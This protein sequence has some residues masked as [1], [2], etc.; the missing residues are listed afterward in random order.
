MKRHRKSVNVNAILYSQN[1]SFTTLIN[2]INDFNIYSKNNN[3]DINII[4]NVITQSNFTH[5]L[6][7]YETLLDYLF[8][9]KSEKYDIIFYDNIYRMRFAPH[10]IDL[11]NILPVDHVDMYMEG[12]ANQTSICNDKLIGLPISVDADVL[13]YNKNYLKKYNQ[14]VPRTW[15]DLIKI[16]KYISNEEK[17]QNNTNLIIYQG[18]FPNHEGGM[19]STYE[20]I[21]SFRDSVNS[22]FPGLTSQIAI[23]ALDKIK[24]IK[25]EIST[26]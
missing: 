15:D 5:S 25:N 22:S 2:I 4:T 14:K 3:L 8:L 21:Y 13:Y 18:Y 16:G 9:K 12:V 26:G 10:L 6:T 24:E 1:G 7:D 11:K 17:K 20:F 19:C 23:N